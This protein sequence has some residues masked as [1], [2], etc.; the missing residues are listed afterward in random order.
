MEKNE[1]VFLSISVLFFFSSAI[2]LH[3]KQGQRMASKVL[4]TKGGKSGAGAGS[5]KGSMAMDSDGWNKVRRYENVLLPEEED[6]E[7]H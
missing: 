2:I 5:G 4:G 1:L 6:R 3:R 7:I